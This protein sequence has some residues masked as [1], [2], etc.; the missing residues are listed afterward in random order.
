LNEGNNSIETKVWGDFVL[1][2]NP[3]EARKEYLDNIDGQAERI[4]YKV[5]RNSLTWKAVKQEA[6]RLGDMDYMNTLRNRNEDHG[7]T[8]YA[9]GAMDALDCLLRFGG[10]DV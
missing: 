3:D 5:D 7:R 9:R 8:Q 2:P 4:Q 6:K 1:G 10:E